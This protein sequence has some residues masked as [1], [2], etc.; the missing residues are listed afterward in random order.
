MGLAWNSIGDAEALELA[1]VLRKLRKLE[2][3]DLAYNRICDSGAEKLASAVQDHPAM[4][5]LDVQ[6]NCIA[7]RGADALMAASEN[8]VQVLL[9]GNNHSFVATCVPASRQSVDRTVIPTKLMKP[10]SASVELRNPKALEKLPQPQTF[11]K[12]MKDKI[13]T[14]PII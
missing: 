2:H 14:A 9:S 8:R 13:A 12:P 10:P 7:N 3:L 5:K 1:L 6:C 4:K 11:Q